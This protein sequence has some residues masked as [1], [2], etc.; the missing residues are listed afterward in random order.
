MPS[1]RRRPPLVRLA[2]VLAEASGGVRPTALELAELL[3]LARHM[4]ERPTVR[5]PEPAAPRQPSRAAPEDSVPSQPEPPGPVRSSGPEG[6]PQS[7]RAPLHLPAPPRPAPART[8]LTEPHAALLAPAP[9]M[10]RHPLALQ[11]SLRPLKRRTA[12]PHRLELDERATADRLARLGAAPEWW[13][14]VLRPAQERWLSLNLLYDTGPTM[15]V[16]RPL[17]RELHTAFAQSGIFRTVSVHRAEP[18]GTVHGSA[19]HAPADGRTVTLLI[20]DCMGP[21]WRPGTAGARWYATLR[22]WAR[23]MP[24][25]VVQPL[26]EHLWRDTALPA[27]PGLLSAPRPAAPNSALSVVP[28]DETTVGA[29]V[30][31][32]VL[33]PDPRWLANWAALVAAPGGQGLPGSVGWLGGPADTA[34]RADFGALSAEELVLRFRASASAAAVRLAGHLALGRPDLP[35]M[36]LVQAAL[37]PRPRPQHLAEVILSGMLTQVPGPPGSYAFR[38]GVR[39]LLLRSLPRTA[40]RGTSDLL[41]R[42][43][44]LIDDRA[45][46]AAGEIRATTPMAAGTVTQTRGEP[47]ATVSEETRDRL[48]GRRPHRGRVLKNRYALDGAVGEGGFLWRAEDVETGAPVVVSLFPAH[49]D[50]ARVQD[51]VRDA[52]ALRAARPPNV[53]TVHD[54]GADDRHQYV[55]MDYVDGITLDSL[56]W[57]GSLR[58]PAPLLVSTVAQLARAVAGMH[59]AGV[60]H[61]RLDTNRVM[62]LPDGGVRLTLFGLGHRGEGPYT[63]DLRALGDLV[64][65]LVSSSYLVTRHDLSPDRLDGLPKALRPAYAQALGLLMSNVSEEQRE[66]LRALRDDGHMR[67]ARAAHD[68]VHYALLGPVSVRR[69]SGHRLATGS[70]AERAMLAMLLL[71]HGRMVTHRRLAEGIWGPEGPAGDPKSLLRSYASR[72]RN[73]LGPGVLAAQPDSYAVHTS[74][75][76]VDVVTCQRLVEQAERQRSEGALDAA[77]TTVDEA[78]NLWRGEALEGVP[79]PAAAAA[80]PRFGQLRLA[81]AVTRAELDLELGDFSRATTFLDDLL[82][83][84]PNR[85]DVR[86]LYLLA[87][88]RQGRTD[89]ALEAYEAYED[90]GGRNPELLALG[91]ELR[92]ALR[93]E[94]PDLRPEEPVH[95]E[96]PPLLGEDEPDRLLVE[97]VTDDDPLETDQRDCARFEFTEGRPPARAMAALRRMVGDLLTAGGLARDQYELVQSGRGVTARMEP[98]VDG[99]PLLRATLDGLAEHQPAFGD[100]RLAV[101]FWQARVRGDT[102]VSSDRPD[103]E[104]VRSVLSA[105]PA[106]AVVALS[107]FWH[108]VEI[109]DGEAADPRDFH[110]FPEG[111]GWYR[112]CGPVAGVRLPAE[113]RAVRGPFRLPYDGEIPEPVDGDHAVVLAVDDGRLDFADSPSVR[114][115]PASVRSGWRWFEVDLRER[116]L[117]GLGFPG[118][119]VSWRVEDPIEAARNPG[120]DLPGLV[121]DVLATA[122]RDEDGIRAALARS[123][124]PGYALRW[125]LPRAPTSPAGIRSGTVRRTPRE[126]VRHA[127]AVL[128]GFDEVLAR[129]YPADE[130]REVLQDV[131]GMLVRERDPA[132]ALAGQPL[133]SSGLGDG[134]DTLSLLRTFAGH[135]LAHAVRDAVDLHDMRAAQRARP[136]PHSRELLRELAARRTPPTVVTDRSGGAVDL[137]LRH[138]G[139]ID[140]VREPVYGRS[141]DLARMM[142]RPHVLLK[143]LGDMG[144]PASECVLIASTTA[145]QAAARAIGLPFIG[146]APTDTTRRHLRAADGDVRLVSSLAPL[147]EAVRSR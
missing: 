106:R 27:S 90:R 12:A 4:E 89:E 110:R 24:L 115:A 103:S 116:R 40:R 117:S 16:W 20:S 108:D 99:A 31:L 49:S 57:T 118:V 11:R 96:D 6:S 53:V 112:L 42:L 104:Q 86:L 43:G 2:D 23:R 56:M 127:Y 141:A 83:T 138:N 129:L 34:D 102:E 113:G 37:E 18:D 26:P 13:L 146:Y 131:A 81:L 93:E 54:H 75:D 114:Q 48:V 17:V 82:R 140:R 19:A 9:P 122:A 101:T 130:E 61:G 67:H 79:G 147:V 63:T 123:H 1:E 135:E 128:L 87:L 94:R 41:S 70:P 105:A 35:V 132:E 126:L 145:E 50:P 84:D 142:P 111:G 28:Y 71:H 143:A 134:A 77:R 74:A 139:L 36:R 76:S 65:R 121:E 109:V 119:S 136:A 22:H 62:L 25:A 69:G 60:P 144:A 45:G 137:F 33:E 100:L 5:P 30:P 64:L 44:A 88:K 66:G 125:S 85:E 8:E 59:D 47:I 120:L 98:Y 32:P 39:D 92:A 29:G 15:P 46:A 51:F 73:A 21:Q 95:E 91:H 3:W 72:L 7:S 97:A 52:E 78:L 38:P 10:L 124:V 80:R 68:P 133:P 55:V 58:L 107:D 14:P